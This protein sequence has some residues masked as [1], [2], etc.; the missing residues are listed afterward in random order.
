MRPL[1][2]IAGLWR[3]RRNPLCRRSDRREAWLTLWA[4]LLIALGAPAVGTLG[5]M[6]AHRELL[7]AIRAQESQRHAVWATVQQLVVPQPPL[8]SDADENPDTEDRYHVIAYWPGPDGATRTGTT[9]VGHRVR[10][11]DRFH[12]W[13]D[14]LGRITTRPMSDDTASSQAA[15]AGLVAAVAAGAAVEAGRRLAVRQLLHRRYARWEDEWA[16]IGP[17]WG[18]TGT[19]N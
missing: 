2:T 16:R 11:G 19:S 18:R 5:G 10:P 8:D 1:H 4:A 6:L 13:T 7:E 14:E 17:D 12:I 15:L 3:W 9:D